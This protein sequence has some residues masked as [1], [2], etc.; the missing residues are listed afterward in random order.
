MLKFIAK[1]L[2]LK[3]KQRIKTEICELG[4]ILRFYIMV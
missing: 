3:F 1:F 2:S 4:L